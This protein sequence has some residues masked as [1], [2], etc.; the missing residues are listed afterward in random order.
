MISKMTS[1][2][3]LVILGLFGVRRNMKVLL[4]GVGAK[5]CFIRDTNLVVA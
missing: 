2:A 5:L 4:I 3:E 1:F